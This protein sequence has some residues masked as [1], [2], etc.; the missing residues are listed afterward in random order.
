MHEQVWSVFVEPRW[1]RLRLDWA[2]DYFRTSLDRLRDAMVGRGADVRFLS[3]YPAF[4]EGKGVNP[5]FAAARIKRS[6]YVANVIISPRVSCQITAAV[7][8]RA[9]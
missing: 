9:S 8:C 1:I 4:F 5:S 2:L 3:L 6:S 7:S